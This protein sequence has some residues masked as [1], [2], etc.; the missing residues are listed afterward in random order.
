V[1]VAPWLAP[2][3]PWLTMLGAISIGLAILG[4]LLVPWW[5]VRMPPDALVATPER[6]P[7]GTLVR[8][9][10]G[11]LLV[12]A[13]V[14]MLVLPGQGLL[15]IALG[16]WVMDVPVLRR[17]ALRG[18]RHRSVRPVIDR[19]RARAGAEPLVWSLSDEVDDPAD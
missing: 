6:G 3:M 14:A 4:T 12:L 10:S 13:G 9:L 18:L 2:W 11:G 17:A 7:V 15:T 5:L 8:G 19:W 16:L 1:S